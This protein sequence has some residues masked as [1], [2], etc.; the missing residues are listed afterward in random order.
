MVKGAYQYIRE[1]WRKSEEL[2]EILKKRLIEWRK[3]HTVERIEKPTR[4]DRARALG[5][6]AKQGF[7]LARVKIR[8]GGRRRKLRGRKGRKPSKAGLVHFTSK[9]SKQTIAE[10][11]AARKF[12]NLEV[13]ASYPVA[14][15][16]THH[17]FEVLLVDPHHPNIIN[18]PKINWIC[19][20]QHR[21]RVL[22]GLTSSAKKSRGLR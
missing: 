1:T 12:K 6:K 14:E 11:K 4:L 13:L 15:N 8:K 7:V 21:K 5:Y 10:I 16:G 17:Y 3:Q 22:R 19:Q 9:L 20:P 2:D 18:D